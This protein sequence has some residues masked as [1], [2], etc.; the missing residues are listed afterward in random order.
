VADIKF[1]QQVVVITGAG[2]G[3]GR[4]YA[5][6]IARRGGKV[7]VNDFGGEV[8]GSGGGKGGGTAASVVQEIESAGGEAIADTHGVHTSEGGAALI[9]AALE[10]Y[11]RLDALIH[12]AGIMRNQSFSKMTAEEWRS[13]LSVHLDGAFYTAHP[14]IL[15][16]RAAGRGRIVF[17]TST[18]GLF[19]N[20]TQ[21]NYSAAKLGLVGL[22]NTLAIEG[23]RYGIKTNCVSPTARTRM[24]EDVDES[25]LPGIGAPPE[26][27][28]PATVYLASEACRFSGAII[29]AGGGFFGRVGVA[30]NNGVCIDG[31]PA[32]VEDIA[33]NADAIFE[34]ESMRLPTED[35]GYLSF[36]QRRLAEP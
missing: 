17:T 3:L 16:M 12:N 8:D 30:H 28:T 25:I 11:G 34:T 14:A 35:E 32:N 2:G 36:I 22:M 27:V 10:R 31:G 5:L 13:V 19:G 23:D 20:F 33:N 29:Q 4:T 21:A 7:V 1:T 15:A 26:H 18:S 24:T 9:S 6:E